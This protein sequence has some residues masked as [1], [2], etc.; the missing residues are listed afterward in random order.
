MGISASRRSL[1]KGRPRRVAE[2]SIRPPW[3][4]VE[5][6]FL[7]ACSRC[8][9]CV[10]VCPEKIVAIGDGGFPEIQFKAGECTF[11]G[12][13]VA[14]CKD[15]ALVRAEGQVPWQLKVKISSDKCLSEQGVTCRVCG[16]RCD[17]RAIRFSLAV[18]G[19]ANVDLDQGKC[20]GCGACFSP[21]PVGA[22]TIFPRT[23]QLKVS[24]DADQTNPFRASS[25]QTDM[26]SP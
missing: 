2:G 22:I 24:A 1:L 16:D 10:P 8:G 25:S 18:G 6:A 13:C 19:V 9:D 26:R 7:N 14:A 3:A 20:T 5:E 17:A 23:S 4:V 12:E 15:K 11:C 21:C